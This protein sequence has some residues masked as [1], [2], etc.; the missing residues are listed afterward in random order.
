MNSKIAEDDFLMS[1]MIDLKRYPDHNE[2]ELDYVIQCV[3]HRKEQ[4]ETSLLGKMRPKV[5]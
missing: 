2:E 1:I 4:L 5:A 3:K